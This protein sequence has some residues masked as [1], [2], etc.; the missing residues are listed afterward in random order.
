MLLGIVAIA[1]STFADAWF[2]DRVSGLD[3]GSTTLADV[4]L[5]LVLAVDVS[6]SMRSV[7]LAI[8]RRGYEAAFRR[9]EVI[10]AIRSGPLGAIAVAYVEWAGPTDQSLIVPWTILSNAESI[11]AFADKIVAAPLGPSF[12]SPPWLMGT[13]ISA[14]ILF[15][16][17]LFAED[18][19]RGTR[20]VIDI[21]GN[22][23]NNNG[24][25]LEG[26]RRR[27]IDQG[28]VI[29]GLPIVGESGPSAFP[30]D[31]YY[32]DCVIGGP[33]AFAIPVRGA[34]VVGEAVRRKLVLEIAE[35]PQRFIPVSLAPKTHAR[36]DCSM[37]GAGGGSAAPAMQATASTVE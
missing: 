19:S 34:D 6:V 31:A 20:K 36:I 2:S 10:D 22:G 32:E 23:P 5:E 21:S 1:G 26:A 11:H 8:Q 9:Q 25:L 14:A 16:G 12:N 37:S 7:D 35:Q 3:D 28:I 24:P 13:S 33:G 17:D 27:V 15:A 4:D 18:R 29:N 30:I